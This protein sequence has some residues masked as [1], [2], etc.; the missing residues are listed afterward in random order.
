[1]DPWEAVPSVNRLH[2]G[3][4]EEDLAETVKAVEALDRRIVAAKADVRDYDGL[5]AAL[6]DG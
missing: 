5:E 4:T 3:A 2:P 6:D 1:M